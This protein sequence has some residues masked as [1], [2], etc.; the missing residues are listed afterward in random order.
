MG[1]RLR[2]VSVHAAGVGEILL[3]NSGKGGSA[4]VD[5]P[6]AHMSD[7]MVYVFPSGDPAKRKAL[8]KGLNRPYSLALWQNYLYVGE[9]DSIKRYPYDPHNL[10]AGPG[11]EIV[12]L[13]GF[14]KDH[15]TRSLLFDRDGTKLYVG[16]GSGAN[17]ETGEDP[18]RAAINRYNPDGTGHELFATGTRNPIGLH[19]Y[20][21]TNFLWAAV[22]ERDELGDDLV[23][24]YFTHVDQDAFLRMCG[25][26]PWRSLR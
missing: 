22:Q 25:D 20:P 16:I 10:T 8:V 6:D 14:N 4:A 23:P 9:A 3:S 18:R 1:R 17:V 11:Q 12:S 19:W 21:N 5:S 24:D 26:G 13:K 2:P 7:G 15:W